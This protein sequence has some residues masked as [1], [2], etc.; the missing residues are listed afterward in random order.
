MFADELNEEMD[1]LSTAEDFLDYFEVPYDPQVVHVNR[2]HILQRFHDYIAQGEDVCGAEAGDVR[3]AYGAALT[4]AYRDFVVSTA[5]REKVFKVFHMN[6]PQK[7]FVS[8]EDLLNA[9]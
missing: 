9:E 8:A 2:L 4:R 6:A 7:T 1:D 5:Q 3:R